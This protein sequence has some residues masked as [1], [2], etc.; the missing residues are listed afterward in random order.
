[1]KRRRAGGWAA[2]ATAMT[3]G[4]WVAISA[5]A[6]S[7]AQE[8]KP[9]RSGIDKSTFDTTV[10]PQDDFFRH[11]NGGWLKTSQ[12]PSDR[13]ADGGF[14][15]LRDEAEANL[16]TLIEDAASGNSPAGS[17]A[18]KIGDLYKS[19]LN[20][21]RAEELGLKPIAGFWPQIE[22]VK[23]GKELAALLGQ[24][25]RLG[26]AG[27][28]ST[29]VSQDEKQA[30]RTIVYLNQGGIGLPDEAYYRDPKY[31]AIR[32]AYV[33][34]IAKQFELAGIAQPVESAKKVM[35][36]ETRLAA[37]HLDRVANRD[38]DKTYNKMTWAELKALTPSF[39]WATYFQAL[40][41]PALSE[42]V[43]SQPAY[44]EAL[45][46]ALTEVP[47][48][49]WKL[50]LDWKVLRTSQKSY[51]QSGGLV[52]PVI[53][54]ALE[55]AGYDR[56]FDLG[57]RFAPGDVDLP[58]LVLPFEE[59]VFGEKEHTVTL[60]PG[61]RLDFGGVAKGW[62]AH[63]AMQRLQ[64]YGSA[65]VDAGGDIAVSDALSD[66]QSWPISVRDPLDEAGS[67]ALLKIGRGG[68]ATSGKDYRR[69]KRD[70]LW[71]HHIINPLSGRPA[72]TDLLTVTI[73]APDA[74]QAEMAAKTVF[75][76]GRENGLS[77][78]R[79]Q[80]ALAALLVLQD[81]TT[82]QSPNL[83]PYLWQTA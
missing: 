6:I 64:Q 3:T 31:A 83:Q 79:S 22:A 77:W 4:V 43:V 16:K 13:P 2:T 54:D 30:D 11:V 49:D 76:L 65:L 33:A 80:D 75:I 26:I 82:V 66:G 53:L 20:E 50:W 51:Q 7:L 9:V 52:T 1:M 28:F 34:H 55:M 81:G 32:E 17:E 37:S 8:S 61:M 74:V 67:I 5:T 41:A 47:L 35:A 10:R 56:S 70:D 63:Q 71:Y 29:F 59:I 38:R 57:L 44:F 14:Y 19:F 18:R 40:K 24:F 46:K 39:D 42:V 78:L 60:P 58:P 36:L 21:A 23:D 72:Q 45:T 27:P 25:A 48:A 73:I 12:I 62:A 15:K 68:V 69:W